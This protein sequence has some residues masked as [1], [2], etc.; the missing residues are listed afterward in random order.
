MSSASRKGAGQSRT[1][2]RLGWTTRQNLSDE[3][4]AVL[5]KRPDLKVV[6]PSDGAK[7]NWE[8]LS[9]MDLPS[10]QVLD[11]FHATEHLKSAVAAA[12]GETNPATNVQ[13]E[14]LRLILRYDEN[15]T[16]KVI[17]PI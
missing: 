6:K 7:D 8:S 1:G 13:F 4:G 15:G 10:P 3:L 17:R 14:K 12:Y 9:E 5:E 2:S 11:F 16:E